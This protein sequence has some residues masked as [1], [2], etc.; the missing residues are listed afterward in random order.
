MIGIPLGLLVQQLRRV[1][2]AS[3]RAAR[4]GEEPQ[5][6][7]E[8]PL[9]RAPPEV[10]PQRDGGRPVHLSLVGVVRQDE[11]GGGPGG[12]RGGA[13]AAPSPWRPSSPRPS[14]TRRRATTA[15]TGAHTWTRTGRRSTCPGTTI[16]T[17]GGIRTRTG[18]SP[19]RSSTCCWALRKEFLSVQPKRARRPSR[20][21]RSPERASEQAAPGHAPRP[22]RSRWRGVSAVRAGRVGYRSSSGLGLAAGRR[23]GASGSPS[24]GVGFEAGGAWPGAACL[25]AP[26][27]CPARAAHPWW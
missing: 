7:L 20:S 5:E 9:A 19:T 1:V 23:A 17:W 4:A 2:A 12:H 13:P 24:A 26:A 6:L 18:A 11:G 27:P 21:A 14:G 25:V 3:V 16:T 10:A 8:L 22:L 15:S